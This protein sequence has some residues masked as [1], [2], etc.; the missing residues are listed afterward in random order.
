MGLWA[1]FQERSLLMMLI[2]GLLGNP[3]FSKS[4]RSGGICFKNARRFQFGFGVEKRPSN[5]ALALG[6][7]A[8]AP[9]P[10]TLLLLNDALTRKLAFRHQMD[11]SSC[12]FISFRRVKGFA[13]D[14]QLKSPTVNIL[15]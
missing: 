6:P 3:T 11:Q 1:S 12:T 5:D 8:R 15:G 4:I 2:S 10:R 7:N 9:L 13:I 14:M